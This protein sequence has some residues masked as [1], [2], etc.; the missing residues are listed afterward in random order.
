MAEEGR[1]TAFNDVNAWT[2]KLKIEVGRARAQ[3]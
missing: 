2:I 1:K 3:A